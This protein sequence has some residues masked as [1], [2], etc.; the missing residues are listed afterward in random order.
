MPS[1]A[2]EADRQ[3]A[4]AL[5]RVVRNQVN[6]Q[7]GNAAD[8]L[9]SLRKRADIA[10]HLGIAPCQVFEGGNVIRV[11]QKT[12]VENQIA[13]RRHSMAVAEAIDRYQHAAL[14]FRSGETVA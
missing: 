6:Q 14:L 12:D 8:K 7:I 1:G 2:A 9:A 5:F 10:S 3:V 11:G 4:F 13:V